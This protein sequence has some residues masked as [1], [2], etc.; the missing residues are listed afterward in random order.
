MRASGSHGWASA[1]SSGLGWMTTATS[2]GVRPNTP[3]ISPRKSSSRWSRS[4]ATSAWRVS[5]RAENDM[6]CDSTQAIRDNVRCVQRGTYVVWLIL[7]LLLVVPGSAS[8]G[9]PGTWTRVTGEDA[10]F[11][12]NLLR[13]GDRLH[14]GVRE[15]ET[16]ATTFRMI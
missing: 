5:C 12:L 16:P 11:E 3:S 13:H 8:A 7:G 10:W 9:G 15:N 1:S 4:A 6:D 14:V 2:H